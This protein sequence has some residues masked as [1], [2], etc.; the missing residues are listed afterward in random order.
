MRATHKPDGQRIA[1][2]LPYLRRYART[3]TGSQESGDQLVRVCLETLIIE[4]ELTQ[5]APNSRLAL[6]RLFHEVWRRI[7]AFGGPESEGHTGS[8]EALEAH[9]LALPPIERQLL[10]LTALELFSVED[11]AAIVEIDP[12][13]ARRLIQKAREEL[14]AQTATTVLVI[15]DEPVI[16]F[17]ISDVVTD[18]GHRVI[19]TAQ[20]RT[21]AVA[22][23]AAKRPGIVLADIQLGDGSSGIDAVREIL[24]SMDVPVIFITAYP[25]RLLTGE[26]PEPIYLVTKPFDADTLRVTMDQ[27]LLLNRKLLAPSAAE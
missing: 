27:A 24:E 7:A 25:E 5:S 9:I 18:M 3:L 11:A 17:D 12:A 2:H 10:L 6:Y 14:T 19:G 23:A 1:P 13:E 16:A 26:G 8:A 20:T 15:E 22:L 21:E 4:P